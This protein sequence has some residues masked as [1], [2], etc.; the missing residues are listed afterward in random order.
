MPSTK[1]RADY[2]DFEAIAKRRRLNSE[3]LDAA[4]AFVKALLRR[5]RE[6]DAYWACTEEQWLDMSLEEKINRSHI[7]RILETAEGKRSV[8]A[9]VSC[10]RQGMADWCMIYRNG[11]GTDDLQ[12]GYA[13]AHCRFKGD[14]CSLE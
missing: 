4:P 13:C 3:E 1:R 14:E 5:P 10:T 12:K 9:C 2:S 8:P 11:A 6:F 7:G